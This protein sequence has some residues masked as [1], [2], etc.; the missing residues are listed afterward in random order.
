VPQR[1]EQALDWIVAENERPC[2]KL[3]KGTMWTVEKK[4]ME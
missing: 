2:S 4:M 1:E 3:C